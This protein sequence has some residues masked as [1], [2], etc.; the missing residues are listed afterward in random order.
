MSVHSVHLSAIHSFSKTTQPSITLIANHGVEG[1]AHAGGTVKHLHN[2]K[3]HAKDVAKAQRENSN[4]ELQVPP[5]QK[6]VHLIQSELFNDEEFRGKDGAN[7]EAG[8]LGENITT[9]GVD[10][11]RLSKGSRLYFAGP[12]ERI[13]DAGVQSTFSDKSDE[14]SPRDK[15]NRNAKNPSTPTDAKPIIRDMPGFLLLLTILSSSLFLL[16][17]HIPKIFSVLPL[18]LLVLF[19]YMDSRSS[20]KSGSTS[21][22]SMTTPVA[23]SSSTNSGTPTIILTGLR[24]PCAKINEFSPGLLA[25]SYVKNNNSEIIAARVGVM[26]VVERG[27]TVKAGMKIVVQEPAVRVDMERI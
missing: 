16:I 19:D 12:G 17:R 3:K 11:V 27:G 2:L 6:Q 5:N 13:T 10:L 9:V 18:L 20:R 14:Y 15:S 8:Q 25:K 23:S 4:I 1:D 22:Q 21:T 24:N 7:V 26:G